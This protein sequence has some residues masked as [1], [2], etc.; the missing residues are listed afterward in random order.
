[1]RNF[2]TS[3]FF[4]LLLIS[5]Q[6]TEKKYLGQD[7]PHYKPEKFTAFNIDL[8]EFR[9]HS[10]PSI[11]SEGTEAF[12]SLFK[13]KEFPQKIYRLE[14]SDG[15][16]NE[17]ELWNKSDLY[18]EGNPILDHDNTLFFY[19]KRSS[20]LLNEHLGQIWHSKRIDEK[21]SSPKRLKNQL[22]EQNNLP[23][24]IDKNKV[25][26]FTA[27][28][29]SNNYAIYSAK[30]EEDEIIGI[31]ELTKKINKDFLNNSLAAVSP[32]GNALI[33]WRFDWKNQIRRGLYVSHKNKKGLWQEPID[34][35]DMINIGEARFPGFSPDGKYIFFTSFRS[36]KEE[37]YWVDAKII[38]FLKNN[39]L[40]L[41]SSFSNFMLENEFS[42]TLKEL[43]RLKRKYKNYYEFNAVFY[44][45]VTINLLAN[46][47]IEKAKKIVNIANQESNDVYLKVLEHILFNKKIDD[48]TEFKEAQEI[49]LNI[50]GYRLIHANHPEIALDVFKLNKTLFPYSFNVYDSYAECLLI[51]GDTLNAIQNFEEVL[52]LDPEN[53]RARTYIENLITKKNIDYDTN[54]R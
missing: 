18:Q 13:N 37:I 21:W 31:Q 12:I 3:V 16:W 1:M 38:E 35:G 40:S 51:M 50:L 10:A 44:E 24:S 39:N 41:I 48:L 49:P 15:E 27:R 20:S 46:D 54:Y 30:I 25:L 26:Y 32:D 7:V 45:N 42:K 52:K 53:M 22:S 17:P 6:P 5:C 36:G 19:S 11:N 4:I 14:F 47:Q 9:I 28:N 33:F 2:L 34:M 23:N 8:E 29:E 43:E